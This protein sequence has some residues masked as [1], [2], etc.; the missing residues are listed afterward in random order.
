MHAHLLDSS[1]LKAL[2]GNS[3]QHISWLDS[4]NLQKAHLKHA[5]REQAA[6]NANRFCPVHVLHC[7]A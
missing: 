6:T 1:G 4:A 5:V 3:S 7:K 2:S